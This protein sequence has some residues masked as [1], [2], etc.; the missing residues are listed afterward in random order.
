MNNPRLDRIRE[1]AEGL[2]KDEKLELALYLI[3]NANGLKYEAKETDLSR[4][5]GTVHFPVDAMEYQNQVRAEWD[6]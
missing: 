5:F 3:A 6:R 4:F 1:L 2:A